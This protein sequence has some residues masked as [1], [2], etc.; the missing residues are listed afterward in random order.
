MCSN[1]LSKVPLS[2]ALSS[3]L[4]LVHNGAATIISKSTT[5]K[6]GSGLQQRWEAK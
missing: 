6:H 3:L 4:Q 1:L 2:T 5:N